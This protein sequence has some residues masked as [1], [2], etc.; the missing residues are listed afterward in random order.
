M[1]NPALLDDAPVQGANVVLYL[2]VR[3]HGETPSGTLVRF[4]PTRIEHGASAD[5]GKEQCRGN[6][7]SR[8]PGSVH[9]FSV[10]P[11]IWLAKKTTPLLPWVNKDK[12]GARLK[13]QV[14]HGPETPRPRQA[15]DASPKTPQGA[16]QF[17]YLRR[18]VLT[19]CAAGS[20]ARRAT[21]NEHKVARAAEK[22]LELM[23][24]S[25]GVPLVAGLEYVSQLQRDDRWSDEEIRALQVSVK[26]AWT[27]SSQSAD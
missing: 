22:C 23:D 17:T 21:M 26:A 25:E 20:S 3:R 1:R 13:V 14:A 8:P 4:S 18:I 5:G 10:P 12:A 2:P 6:D 16:G 24:A 9:P 7:E 15:V 11:R 27:R 19:R